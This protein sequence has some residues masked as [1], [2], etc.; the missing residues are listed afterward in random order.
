[1][2]KVN[3]AVYDKRITPRTNWFLVVAFGHRTDHMHILLAVYR[4]DAQ[5]RCCD[6]LLDK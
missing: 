3:I 5:R 6:W 2:C 4:R 1:M